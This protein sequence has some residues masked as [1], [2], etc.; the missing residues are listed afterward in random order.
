MTRELCHYELSS[1]SRLQ[2]ALDASVP[3]N[4][5]P[6]LMDR[7]TILEFLN[8]LT[9]P[10]QCRLYAFYWIRLP[11]E[12]LKERTCI[13]NGGFFLDNEGIFELG[14]SILPQWENRGYATEAVASLVSWAFDNHQIPLIIAR[15]NPYL[16]ASVRVL[17]KNQF[18]YTGHDSKEGTVTYHRFKIPALEEI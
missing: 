12:E 15:T 13:G 6:V 7:D 4:W 3:D 1:Q 5:P 9:D 18:V 11:D 16:H 8:R 2:K 10:L 14:Y 17:E